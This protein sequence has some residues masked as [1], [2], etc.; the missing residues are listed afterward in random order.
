MFSLFS[1]KPVAA[2]PAPPI[3]AAKGKAEKGDAKPK[4]LPKPDWHQHRYPPAPVGVPLYDP[5][6][7]LDLHPELIYGIRLASGLDDKGF[8]AHYLQV[9]RNYAHFVHVLPASRAHHHRNMGGMLRHG[10]EVASFAMRRSDMLILG[11]HESPRQRFQDE[12]I[13]RFAMF[14]AA[15][16]H[17]IGKIVADIEVFDHSGNLRWNPFEETLVE[18]GLR[19]SLTTYHPHWSERRVHRAHEAMSAV[20][21]NRLLDPLHFSYLA[22]GAREILM[23]VATTVA[24]V[25]MQDNPLYAVVMAADHASVSASLGSDTRVVE[26]ISVG[27]SP[28]ERF[29]EAAVRLLH[30]GWQV[31]QPGA[32]VLVSKTACYLAWPQA[33]DDVK[34]RLE[35]EGVTGILTTPDQVAGLLIDTNFA[36]PKQRPNGGKTLYHRVAP[37]FKSVSVK[38]ASNYLKLSGFT[39]LFASAPPKPIDLEEIEDIPRPES[40]PTESEVPPEEGASYPEGEIPFEDPPETPPEAAASPTPAPTSSGTAPPLASP[41][42]PPSSTTPSSTSSAT[43]RRTPPAPSTGGQPEAPSAGGSAPTVQ[44]QA[45]EYLLRQRGAAGQALLSLV[46]AINNG[47]LAP[48]KALF[49]E[50]TDLLLSAAAAAKAVALDLANLGEVLDS[51]GILIVDPKRPTTR[52]VR[53]VT[54]GGG[55]VN[56]FRI[57]A[58]PAAAMRAMINR[59]ILDKLDGVVSAA[60]APASSTPA[61]QPPSSGQAQSTADTPQPAAANSKPSK[62]RKAGQ[63]KT[64]PP[65]AAPGA[66]AAPAEAPSQAPA[67]SPPVESIDAKVIRDRIYAAL[68]QLASVSPLPEGIVRVENDLIGHREALVGYLKQKIPEAPGKEIYAAAMTLLQFAPTQLLRSAGFAAGSKPY[69]FGLRS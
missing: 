9:A 12:A 13:W 39:V 11:G 23:H 6:A 51:N 57:S 30:D 1:K 3:S 41:A 68:N 42:H 29:I 32:R 66:A 16:G 34:A 53:H 17:D 67:A 56:C 47:D 27:I 38:L 36:V 69:R 43:P 61:A 62:P 28:A 52:M 10:L 44:Q 5:D 14:V 65:A 59:K 8:A 18:W 49:A 21:L 35:R 60:D 4:S 54:A 24:G 20:L 22:T 2:H 45:K 58:R 33:F 31:N 48:G 63:A 7:L 50:K 64:P 37:D 46:E 26:G 25:A 40:P 19:N 15:I 55:A